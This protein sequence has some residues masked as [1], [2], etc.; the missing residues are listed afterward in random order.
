MKK[1]CVEFVQQYDFRNIL[2]VDLMKNLNF[3]NKVL[4]MY[5]VLSA[6]RV[7]L[8]RIMDARKELRMK[9][10]FFGMSP[11][12]KDKKLLIS[13]LWRRVGK[14]NHQYFHSIIQTTK[15][16]TRDIFQT[17]CIMVQ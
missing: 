16:L 9:K 8:P 14:V 2:S 5:D 3:M 4:Q 7:K 13:K 15:Y 1:N 10:E 11:L 17:I 6:W 12:G